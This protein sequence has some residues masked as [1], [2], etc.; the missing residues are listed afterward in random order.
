MSRLLIVFRLYAQ[1]LSSHS[2]TFLFQ[3]TLELGD[4][5][6]DFFQ[7]ATKEKSKVS[8]PGGLSN[9]KDFVVDQHPSGAYARCIKALYGMA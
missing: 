4:K 9:I 2:L 1:I 8:R 6:T 5:S 3:P 7:V